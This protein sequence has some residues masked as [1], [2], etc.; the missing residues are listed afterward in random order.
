MI[1]AIRKRQSH[2]NSSLGV[3]HRKYTLLPFHK[4]RKSSRKPKSH[5][6]FHSVSATAKRRS[7]RLKKHPVA[8]VGRLEHFTIVYGLPRFKRKRIVG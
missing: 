8:A 5:R 1:A 7:V 4:Q 6:R 2:R 3:C